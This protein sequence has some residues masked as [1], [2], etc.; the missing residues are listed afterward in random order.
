MENLS[1][2]ID[3]SIVGSGEKEEQQLLLET[4]L[5][6]ANI[7]VVFK[8]PDNIPADKNVTS[9]SGGR[10]VRYDVYK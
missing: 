4:A 7:K 9:Y 3:R 6:I 5:K 1:N 10:V 8:R 2:S